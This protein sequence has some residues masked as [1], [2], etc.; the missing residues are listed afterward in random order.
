M[1][2]NPCIQLHREITV[3]IYELRTYTFHVG[4]LGEAVSLYHSEGWPALQRYQDKLVGYFTGDI[5]AM[6]Q[7]VHLWKFE[8]DAD[9]RQHWAAVFA[10]AEFMAF[11]GKLR[12]MILTQE[13]KLLAP[14]PWGPHP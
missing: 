9:R 5:G 8:D 11:A 12:P 6:N 3:A 7:L 13:N 2:R 1:T 14:S 4:R 10:D